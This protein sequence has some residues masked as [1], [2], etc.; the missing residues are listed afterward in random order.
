[1]LSNLMADMKEAMKNKDKERLQAI[2]NM[3][4]AIKAK[5][6]DSRRVLSNDEAV[7][8]VLGMAKK[9]KDSIEQYKNGGRED[10]AQNELNELNVV[11]SYLPKQLN[12]NEL[13]EIVKET[14]SACGA[15]SMADI[16]NVMP[17]LM[18]KIAGKGDGKLASNIVREILQG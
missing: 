11:E 8:L 2:R 4:A 16:K 1:M 10:L 18:P 5:Q 13:R 15:K 6:I 3:I 7:K 17:L 12:E 14:I 9:L